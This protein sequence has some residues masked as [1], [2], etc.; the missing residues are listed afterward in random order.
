MP[1]NLALAISLL[2]NYEFLI[3]F[4]S[5][6]HP[7]CVTWRYGACILIREVFVMHVQV[8]NFN[9]KDMTDA[10]YRAICDDFTPAISS[11]PGLLSKVWLADEAANTYGGVYFWKDSQAMETYAQGDIFN[12]IATNPHFVNITATDY[13]IV[14]GPTVACRGLAA[15]VA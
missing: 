7:P 14:E 9:L 13:G 5:H 8:V 4:S 6:A 15:A 10:E 1:Q 12:A 11:I 2:R 3:I